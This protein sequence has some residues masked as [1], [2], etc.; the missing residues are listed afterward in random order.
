MGS[1]ARAGERFLQSSVKYT[2]YLVRP[3]GGP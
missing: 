3:E 1:E 2:D